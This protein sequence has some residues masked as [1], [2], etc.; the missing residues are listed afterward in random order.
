MSDAA[1]EFTA[2]ERTIVDYLEADGKRCIH[3]SHEW[4]FEADAHCAFSIT[5]LACAIYTVLKTAQGKQE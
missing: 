3:E 4:I 2:I 5:A 1:S